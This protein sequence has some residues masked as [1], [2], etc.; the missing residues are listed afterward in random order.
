METIRVLD[1]IAPK[2]HLSRLIS[3]AVMHYVSDRGRKKLAEQLKRGAIAN[4][5]RDLEIAREWFF[6]DEEAWQL[7]RSTTQR[8]M[9]SP[10]T[11]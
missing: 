8:K 11:R 6:I 5:Q 7:A 1:R 3:E 9:K 4:A 2:G 10:T